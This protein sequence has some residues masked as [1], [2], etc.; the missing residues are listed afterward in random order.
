M[1]DLRK[2]IL[3]HFKFDNSFSLKSWDRETSA[4]FF[5]NSHF[6]PKRAVSVLLGE[7]CCPTVL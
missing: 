6:S 3:A 2:K 1:D 4:L 7:E 5:T